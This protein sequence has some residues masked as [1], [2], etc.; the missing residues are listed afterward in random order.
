MEKILSVLYFC[1]SVSAFSNVTLARFNGSHTLNM[2]KVKLVR[3]PEISSK[4]KLVPQY[5]VLAFVQGELAKL[6][7]VAQKLVSPP[8][9]S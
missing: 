1:S 3:H 9:L 6:K 5:L 2:P 8:S 7:K 4:M